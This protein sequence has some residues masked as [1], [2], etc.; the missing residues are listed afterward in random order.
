M[1]VD[2]DKGGFSGFLVND[3]GLPNLV[4]KRASSHSIVFPRAKTLWV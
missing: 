2:E 1:T 3:V 4:V